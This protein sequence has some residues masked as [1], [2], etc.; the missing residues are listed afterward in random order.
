MYR[1]GNTSNSAY[2]SH[3][4][5]AS[6]SV[7]KRPSSLV[8]QKPVGLENL[9]NTCY[10]SAILQM[11]FM[12]LPDSLVKGNG[13]ITSLF[14]KLKATKDTKDYANFKKEVEKYIEIVQGNEQQDAQ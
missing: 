14:Y 5:H 12:I 1:T 4:N 2:G 13:K 3:Y 9:G 6:Y 7:S 11:L 8:S 10:I